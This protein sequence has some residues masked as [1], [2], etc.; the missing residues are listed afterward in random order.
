VSADPIVMVSSYP[1][2][3]CGI[4]TFCEEAREFV[5]K[6]QP[7]R[8]VLVTSHLDGEG[9]G[10]FPLIDMRRSDWWRPV[11]EKIDE[12]SPH[13]VHLQHEYGLYEYCDSR[14][15]GDGNEGFLKLL[16]AIGGH[17]TVVELH[18]V[19][20][21]LR[22]FE[23]DFLYRLS[24]RS[25][26]LLFKC[27]YQ[28]WRLDWNFAGRGWAIPRNIQVIPHGA[29]PDRRW[30][31]HEI[32]ELRRE[33]GLDAAG[34]ADHVVGMIGWIQ[35]NKRWDILLSMWEE[36]HETLKRR[37]GME[38]D[39]LAAG[40]MRDAAHRDDYERWRS[41]ALVLAEKGIAHYH[42]FVP[43]G[44]N[45]YKMM[46]ICDFIVLP[47]IDETQSGTLARVIALN[48]PFITTAPMEG[49]TA[50]TLES[51]GG[52]LF[53][54]KAMLREKVLKLA[55][56]ERLRLALGEKLKKYLENV[57][58]W[59]VVARQYHAAYELARAALRSGRPVVLEPEF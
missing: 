51:E 49:L 18:T 45:Y 31:V 27:H 30:G 4:A 9:E 6:A 22:D 26:V 38:W 12:L 21:R 50:Q 37:T 29:R 11:A 56:D 39:L 15:V 5:R 57:V 58:S 52:L 1:P 44:D 10:V 53:T 40:A 36:I 28:K 8:D 16:E 14:G 32:P 33:F 55:E 41:E 20:G 48:K 17:P 3:L 35:S 24:Q 2:R 23:A 19:H 47:S 25:H 34:L 7:D 13:A 43:R 42:E 59:E 54:T 46:A